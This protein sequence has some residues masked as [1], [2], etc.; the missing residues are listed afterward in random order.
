M[1]FVLSNFI[2]PQH[3]WQ[4]PKLIMIIYF[5]GKTQISPTRN[6]FVRRAREIHGLDQ[7]NANFESF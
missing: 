3:P 4:C 5:L 6:L 2:L 1:N 7:N